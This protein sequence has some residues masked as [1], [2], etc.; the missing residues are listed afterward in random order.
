MREEVEAWE[1]GGL[2]EAHVC[3]RALQRPTA[4][5]AAMVP[6][7]RHAVAM[8]MDAVRG[9]PRTTVRGRL[10][11]RPFVDV[12]RIQTGRNNKFL[13]FQKILRRLTRRFLKVKDADIAG[14]H[15]STQP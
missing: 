6:S 2:A 1:S 14:H 13:D 9:R 10:S 3:P 7:P 5:R 12:S 8:Y 15:M 4:P 11:N